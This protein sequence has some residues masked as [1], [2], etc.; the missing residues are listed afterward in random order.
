MANLIGNKLELTCSTKFT[1]HRILHH[2][3]FGFDAYSFPREI[4]T[5]MHVHVQNEDG[6]VLLALYE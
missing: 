1:I 6:I 4:C 5:D 2:N 3:L